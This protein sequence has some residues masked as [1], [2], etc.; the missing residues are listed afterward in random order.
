[1]KL[2]DEVREGEREKEEEGKRIVQGNVFSSFLN[3][4][5]FEDPSQLFNDA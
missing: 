2:R 5:A 1:M 4:D 3:Y